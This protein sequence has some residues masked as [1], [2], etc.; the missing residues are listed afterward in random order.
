M[1]TVKVDQDHVAH[2]QRVAKGAYSFDVVHAST[3]RLIAGGSCRVKPGD[4]AEAVV[5]ESALKRLRLE[6]KKRERDSRAFADG[7]SVPG[8]PAR[9]QLPPA[10]RA[11]IEAGNLDIDATLPQKLI[12]D[13]YNVSPIAGESMTSFEERRRRAAL[14]IGHQ[15]LIGASDDLIIGIAMGL[16]KISG[17]LRTGAV[18]EVVA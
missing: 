8:A 11:A 15:V 16:L 7:K 14:T 9:G 1:R 12:R 18:A 4:E 17:S 6:A 5:A 10:E 2:Y 3:S 13:A